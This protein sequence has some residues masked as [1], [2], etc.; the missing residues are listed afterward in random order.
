VYP[1]RVLIRVADVLAAQDER[2]GCWLWPG[3]LSE[4]GVGLIPYAHRGEHRTALAH[5]AAYQARHGRPPEGMGVVQTCGTRACVNPAHLA[6]HTGDDPTGSLRPAVKP[7]AK[8]PS[9]NGSKLDVAAVAA[10]LA[11]T[12]SAS[13]LAARHGV[14]VTTIGAIRAGRAWRHVPRP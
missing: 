1:A 12:E 3:P 5:V 7:P 14:T 8:I 13:V 2:E 10:I 4:T 11:S 6:L 9:T